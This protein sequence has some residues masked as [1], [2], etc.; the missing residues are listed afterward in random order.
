VLLQERE[1]TERRNIIDYSRTWIQTMHRTLLYSSRVDGKDTLPLP[2]LDI[3]LTVLFLVGVVASAISLAK[4]RIGNRI[5]F[6][7]LGLSIFYTL[8]MLFEHYKIYTKYGAPLAIQGRYLLMILPIVIVFMVQSLSNSLQRST[9][10]YIGVTCTILLIIGVLQGGG[11]L[12]HIIRAEPNF[13]W[14]NSVSQK[15]NIK[16][17]HLLERFVKE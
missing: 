5:L 17:K 1:F 9:R 11:I 3:S 10:A 13:Y 15:A 2:I 16:T 8:L 4:Y 6:I 7:L 14:Q 12:T